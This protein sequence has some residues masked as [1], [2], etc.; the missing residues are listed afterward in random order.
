[1]QS[2]LIGLWFSLRTHASQIWR[3][4]QQLL[5][6]QLDLP[7]H[8][9]VSFHPKPLVSATS[10]TN[11]VPTQPP[12]LRRPTAHDQPNASAPTS[13]TSTA[14]STG[15]NSSPTLPRRV[16]YA[17]SQ[18]PSFLPV[19]ESVDQAVKNDLQ[20]LHLPAPM[21]TDDFT[22]AVAVATV[23]ALRHQQA[24]GQASGKLR[25][26]MGEPDGGEH[27]GH[28]APSWSRFVSASVLLSCTALYALIAGKKHSFL[29]LE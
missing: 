17:V 22:R 27:G 25:A 15:P 10:T 13:A 16:S 4:P 12:L 1:M 2:Y 24:H 11:V 9:R 7:T 23:S 19:M 8:Q 29:R 18:Q 28:D 3:N 5:D 20:H 6:H 21:T 26:S 14:R